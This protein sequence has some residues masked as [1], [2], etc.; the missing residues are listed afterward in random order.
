MGLDRVAP[1]QNVSPK[2]QAQLEG[3]PLLSRTPVAWGRVVL[4]DPISLL[5]DHAFLEKKAATN[6]L[7]LLTRWPNDWLDGWVETM[8]AVARDE[9]A[10]LA[11][12]TRLLTR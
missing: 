2:E 8:T 10:H 11:Q 3:L 1:Y 6:A 12:V 7:E 9:M 4:A 5:I